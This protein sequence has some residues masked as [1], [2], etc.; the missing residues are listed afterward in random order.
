[1]EAKGSQGGRGTARV[2][3]ATAQRF[4]LEL[5]RALYRQARAA[6]AA[7]CTSMPEC[8]SHSFGIITSVEQWSVFVMVAPDI[9]DM[10]G[11]F[12]SA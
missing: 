7:N 1:M 3:N 6:D 11:S 8:V 12:V 2:Q 5:Y 9:D 10:E 4:G